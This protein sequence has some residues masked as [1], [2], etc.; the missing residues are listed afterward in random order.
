MASQPFLFV[1][2]LRLLE[3][4]CPPMPVRGLREFGL[5]AKTQILP[6]SVPSIQHISVLTSQQPLDENSALESREP[7]KCK[8]QYSRTRN[9][10]TI[11]MWKP[12]TPRAAIFSKLYSLAP[13]RKTERGNTLIGKNQNS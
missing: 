10:P 8:S 9:F 2:Y 3:Q 1:L 11:G 7:P 5:G 13:M 6:W 4:E 12:S